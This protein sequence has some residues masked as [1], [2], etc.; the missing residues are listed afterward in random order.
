MNDELRADATAAYDG[1]L[2]LHGPN[3]L[4]HLKPDDAPANDP[5]ETVFQRAERRL[6][7]I[8]YWAWRLRRDARG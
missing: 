8:D 1:Y 5:G 4:P 7:G 2:A 3:I 6:R